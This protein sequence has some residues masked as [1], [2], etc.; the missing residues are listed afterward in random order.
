MKKT[1]KNSIQIEIVALPTELDN[2]YSKAEKKLE[3]LEK[4]L[5]NSRKIKSIKA[6]IQEKKIL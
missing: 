4:K 3:Q 2:E 5:K 1:A 6:K